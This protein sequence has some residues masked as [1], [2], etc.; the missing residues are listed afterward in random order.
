MMM[1]P[2]TTLLACGG[3]DN[4]ARGGQK[5]AGLAFKKSPLK[6]LWKLNRVETPNGDRN[7]GCPEILFWLQPSGSFT[8]EIEH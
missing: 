7:D 3:P 1:T 5:C 6:Q 8:L 4:K 2:P